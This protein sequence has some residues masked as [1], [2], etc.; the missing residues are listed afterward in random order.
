MRGHPLNKDIIVSYAR[1][2]VSG[3]RGLMQYLFDGLEFR[4]DDHMVP[5]SSR[6]RKYGIRQRAEAAAGRVHYLKLD[7][8]KLYTVRVTG[9]TKDFIREIIAKANTQRVTAV[10]TKSGSTYARQ[11][12]RA[13]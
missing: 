7:D 3:P 2:T 1:G 12:V 4:W 9:A 5:G 11:F 8:D 6:R 13:T 10:Y